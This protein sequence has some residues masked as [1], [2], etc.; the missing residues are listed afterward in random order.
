MKDQFNVF[1]PIRNGAMAIFKNSPA[2]RLEGRIGYWPEQGRV[3][4]TVD[5]SA[6]IDKCLVKQ[7]ITGADGILPQ[8]QFIAP[9]VELP[10]LE[11]VISLLRM[12]LPQDKQNNNNPNN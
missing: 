10:I 8:T 11:K 5:I 9:D 6:K 2:G 3:Y 1:I 7:I 4:F 12:R